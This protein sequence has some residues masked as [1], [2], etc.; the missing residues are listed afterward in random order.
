[1][2]L[3]SR[4]IAIRSWLREL[5]WP[6][7]LYADSGNGGHLLYRVN[8][9]RDDEGLLQRVLKAIAAKHDDSV[10]EVDL[11]VHNAARISKL[12]G[13]LA[14]KGDNMPERP[15]RMARLIETPDR[16]DPVA[17][18]LLEAV[19]LMT[20]TPQAH[21]IGQSDNGKSVGGKHDFD[22]VEYL[23]SHGVEVGKHKALGDGDILWELAA[24]PVAA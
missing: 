24:L 23:K 19:A 1:M 12:Y 11:G 10:V 17:Q 9:P 2:R 16:L 21:H 15:H 14:C 3:L 18:E 4:A 20:Q 6:D 13:T 8:L 5:G 22:V 7:P